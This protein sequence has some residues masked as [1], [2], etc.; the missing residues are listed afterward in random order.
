MGAPRRCTCI[1]FDLPPNILYEILSAT[2]AVTDW[3]DNWPLFN[4]VRVSRMRFYVVLAEKY[5]DFLVNLT[6]SICCATYASTKCIYT[7]PPFN[8]IQTNHMSFYAI[9]TE[10]NDW[11]QANC[12]DE[13]RCT[14][15]Q[16]N[17]CW[18]C[19]AWTKSLWES[20]GYQLAKWFD[21]TCSS[22]CHV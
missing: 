13:W 12:F 14:K 16:L 18:L 7:W 6:H 11:M 22:K 1:Y 8:F 20:D 21:L 15:Y 3:V 2:R 17:M 19:Y 9:A 10:R 5:L 4:F